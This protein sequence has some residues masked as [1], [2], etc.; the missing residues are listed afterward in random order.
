MESEREAAALE[1]DRLAGEVDGT[2]R[3]LQP[4]CADPGSICFGRSMVVM[5]VVSIKCKPALAGV[6]D[7]RYSTY[8]W[9]R[10]AMRAARGRR[11][12]TN[13]FW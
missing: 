3:S 8:N 6:S 11:R 2:W 9:T 12:C 5:Y 7:E 4:L 10:M 1:R 13:H